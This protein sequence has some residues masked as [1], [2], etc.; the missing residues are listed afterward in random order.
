MPVDGISLDLSGQ[1]GIF[2]VLF[3]RVGAVLMMLPGF[4]EESVPMRIRLL[5]PLG[6]TLALFAVLSARV[7]PMLTHERMLPGLVISEMLIGIAMG[8]IVR[9]MFFAAA[10]AGSI[11]TMQVGLTSALVSDPSQGGQA[12]V[13]SKL[14][15]LAALILCLGAGIHHMWIA[16]IVR[17]YDV[18]TLGALP[19]AEDF[20]QLAVLTIGQAMT[21][22]LGL[23][24]PLVIYGILFN[25]ALGMASRVAPAIQL[26]FMAQP[27]NLMLGLALLTMIFG[28]ILGTFA[29]AMADWMRTGWV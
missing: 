16:S 28:A 17:S 5:I 15:S 3:A 8:M 14:V 9:I 24:A 12:P 19:A 21:L 27:L 25:V 7:A 23:A 18:F 29:D 4:S 13:L 10:M 2:L 11:I 1:A 22:A 26:F 20:M 6:M